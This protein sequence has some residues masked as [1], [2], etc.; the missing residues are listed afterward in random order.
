MYFKML[1]DSFEKN[2]V[3]FWNELLNGGVADELFRRYSVL[4]WLKCTRNNYLQRFASTVLGFATQFLPN[5]L[6]PFFA[7]FFI[8]LL[9]F[10]YVNW[11]LLSLRIFSQL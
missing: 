6:K 8:P 7:G 9:V 4:S 10:L 11:K 1:K 5:I 3:F 2:R